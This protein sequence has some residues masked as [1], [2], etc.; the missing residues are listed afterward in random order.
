MKI[1]I[2]FYLE[3][4]KPTKDYLTLNNIAIASGVITLFMILCLGV[5]HFNIKQVNDKLVVMEQKAKQAQNLLAKLQKDLIRHNDKATFNNQ[6]VMLD[7]KL[8]AK[9]LLWDGVGKRL[10]NKTVDY[11]LV[12]KELTQ[13][14]DH[15]L[16]LSQF[17]FNENMAQF[18]GFALDSSAVTRWMTY[19]QSSHSFK[20]LEFSYLNLH[21]VDDELIQFDVATSIDVL[22]KVEAK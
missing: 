11:Y 7:K 9:K 4:L 6:K 12:L 17:A 20:G 5:I 16:W 2:N 14:H 8:K 13:H 22:Q 18:N 10:E 15:D 21:S 19:L 1:S 3:D